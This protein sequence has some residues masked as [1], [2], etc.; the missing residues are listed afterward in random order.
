MHCS[1]KSITFASVFQ[2]KDKMNNI[3]S[4]LNL[5]IR[6]R[7]HRVAGSDKVCI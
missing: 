6:I 2:R 7:L 1:V 5:I 3:Q 4:I